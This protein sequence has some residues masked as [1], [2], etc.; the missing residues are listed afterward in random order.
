MATYFSDHFTETASGTSIDDPRI[1]VNA[2]LK[3]AKMRYSR[4]TVTAPAAITTGDILPLLQLKTNDRIHAIYI[5]TPSFTGTG[6]PADLGIYDETATTA[7]D[8]DCF[9]AEDAPLDD[10]TVAIARVDCFAIGALENED[11]GKR[12]F[13]LVDEALGTAVYDE[14]TREVWTLALTMGT[15]STVTAGAEIVCEVYYTSE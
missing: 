8:D 12:L 3:H 15:E 5:S 1:K 14:D 9:A 6:Q 11:R 13:E 2:G 7:I 4:A 10:L